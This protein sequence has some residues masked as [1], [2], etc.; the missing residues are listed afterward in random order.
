MRIL[1]AFHVIIIKWST[2]GSNEEGCAHER[3]RAGTYLLDF[4]DTVW[5]RCEIVEV[6]AGQP[7]HVRPN[8]S[9]Y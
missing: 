5:K 4:R 7:D 2:P 9:E 6:L 1:F 8:S 3:C